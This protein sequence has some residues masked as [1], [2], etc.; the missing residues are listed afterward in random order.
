M[1]QSSEI[2][3]TGNSH[4]LYA[5]VPKEP[6]K[7][8]IRPLKQPELLDEIPAE[9]LTE[10]DDILPGPPTASTPSSPTSLISIS[11]T[12]ESEFEDS[13]DSFKDLSSNSE[14]IRVM[15]SLN[16]PDNMKDEEEEKPEPSVG[17]MRF[18]NNYLN[19]VN[20]PKK[21]HLPKRK[22]VKTNYNLLKESLLLNKRSK[23]RSLFRV[24]LLPYE[25]KN[26]LYQMNYIWIHRKNA[27]H[28][29][30][31]SIDTWKNKI[32]CQMES[33]KTDTRPI[34]TVRYVRLLI[35]EDINRYCQK[36]SGWIEE[37]NEIDYS[38]FKPVFVTKNL[39]KDFNFL[40]GDR[41]FIQSVN[42]IPTAPALFSLEILIKVL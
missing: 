11:S 34:A 42:K 9:F 30:P 13:S 2:Y 35:L 27:K 25:K 36:L 23:K 16:H 14:S 12:F 28:L 20:N 8:S 38:K 19:W 18:L 5:P 10:D 7:S 26:A 15:K 40:Q 1:E 4:R 21:E 3:I 6:K 24:Q 33:I 32:I 41:V 22:Q 29:N 39:L 31:E 37:A 17:L